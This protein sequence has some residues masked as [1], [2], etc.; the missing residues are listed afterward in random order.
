MKFNV[1]VL[2]LAFGIWWGGGMFLMTWW[3]IAVGGVLAPLSIIP[4]IYIGY[5][6]TPLGSI[7]GLAW[8]F[9][10]GLVCGWIF[11][12]LYNLLAARFERRTA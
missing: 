3:L 6:L 7:I 10:D 12:W 11:A 8:G 5:A 4:Q 1:N 2:A 9:V